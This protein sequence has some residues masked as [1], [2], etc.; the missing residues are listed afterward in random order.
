MP[1][2]SPIRDILQAIGEAVAREIVRLLSANSRYP[3]RKNSALAQQLLSGQAVQVVQ[4]RGAGGR[5]EGYTANASIS[6]MALDYLQWVDTGR[7]PGG[8]KVP[9]AALLQFIKNRGLGQARGKG[10]KFGAFAIQNAI[11]K[12]GIRGRHVLVPAFVLGQDLTDVYLNNGLLDAMT[13][14]IETKYFNTAA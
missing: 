2:P 12:N 7:A 5:F 14:E 8:K 6:L 9:L 3:L 4:G 1:A 11:Y 13:L 10:G